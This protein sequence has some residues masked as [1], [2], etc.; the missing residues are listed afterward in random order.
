MHDN[1]QIFPTLPPR[2]SD[3]HTEWMLEANRGSEWQTCWEFVLTH[4][5]TDTERAAFWNGASLAMAA[6]LHRPAG[7]WLAYYHD[8]SGMAVFDQEVDAL[9]YAVEHSTEVAFW[10]YGTDWNEATL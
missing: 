10:T 4:E 1:P 9:R 6:A 7:V 8:R 5:L 2:E 3:E